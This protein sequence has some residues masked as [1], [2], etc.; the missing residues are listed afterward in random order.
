MNWSIYINILAYM[1]E[2]KKEV[3]Y[4]QEVKR[5]V[6]ERGMPVAEFARRINRSHNTV[7]SIFNREF[8]DLK[9]LRDISEV[10]DFDFI[11]VVV[12]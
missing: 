2:Q 9:L 12:L 1:K 5:R 10:L 7:Y 11:H 8:I 4:G 3:H 6:D